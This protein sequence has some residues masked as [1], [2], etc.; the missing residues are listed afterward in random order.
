MEVA[1]AVKGLG[2]R[3][4]EKRGKGVGI[5]AEVDASLARTR[6][7]C[8]EV[9]GARWRS[10]LVRDNGGGG[11]DRV[12]TKAWGEDDAGPSDGDRVVRAAWV[13]CL[14]EGRPM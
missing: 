6:G 13:A 5:V 7:G 4:R 3:V 2:A 12:E 11:F 8:G 1:A 10:S 9:G 14:R